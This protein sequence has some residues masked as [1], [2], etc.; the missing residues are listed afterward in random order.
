MRLMG[1]CL[2][3]ARDLLY[4][5]L[6]ISATASSASSCAAAGRASFCA[7]A[8]RASSCGCAISRSTCLSRAGLL[9]DCLTLVV[10]NLGVHIVDEIQILLITLNQGVCIHEL[11]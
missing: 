4:P 9:T 11:H 8:G 10:N 7:A 5:L 2:C 1:F 6:S 3:L